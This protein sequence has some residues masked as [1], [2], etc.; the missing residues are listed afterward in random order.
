MGARSFCAAVY[1]KLRV[2]LPLR[3]E[4]FTPEMS[5]PAAWERFTT[6]AADQTRRSGVY[7]DALGESAWNSPPYS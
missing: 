4:V 3:N 6:L 7:Q 1:L 5:R 2:N